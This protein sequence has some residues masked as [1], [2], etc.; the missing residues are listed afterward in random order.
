MPEKKALIKEL[1]GLAREN[2]KIEPE[3]YTKYNVKRGLR[4]EDGSGVLVGL[5]TIGDVH[6]YIIDE[7]ET[8]PVEGRLRYRGID[9]RDLVN[10]FQSEKR[11]GF[12][13]TVFLLLFGKLPTKSELES[14]T[15]LLGSYRNLPEGFK[16]NI[17]LKSPGKN[18]MNLLIR[19]VSVLYSYDP[20]PEDLSIE[21]VLEQ[22]IKLIA[23]FPAMVAYAYHAKKHYHEGKSLHLHHQ[24]S[25]HSHAE[26]FLSLIR[27]NRNY[28]ELEAAVLD[29]CLVL[30][31]EHGGGNNSTFTVHVVSSTGTDTYSA[32]A[33]A[34][35]SLKG[36]KHGGANTKVME[37]MEDAKKEIKDWTNENQIRDYIVRL[38]KKEAF[39]RSGLIYGMG[40]AVYSL[41]DPRAELLKEKAKELAAATKREEEFYL[42]QKIEELGKVIFAEMKGSKVICANVDFYSGFVYDMLDIEEDLHTPLFAIARIA[43]WS[44]HLIEEIVSGGR[45]IR[46]AYKYVLGE[47]EYIPLSQRG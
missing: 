46:P 41:S 16:E 27:T 8:K 36:P 10:G 23:Q 1:S 37:M 5:T 20:D 30:H 13:E 6:G 11:F 33:A 24:L 22:C 47:K 21:H 4:N 28:T 17:I 40:H 31:A 15:E 43:G 9:V 34:I 12:E 25:H 7:G 32:I 18:L 39:D 14:F 3:L 2:A 45:I 26:N 42:Y 44:A 19:Q 38:L 35:G 29:L